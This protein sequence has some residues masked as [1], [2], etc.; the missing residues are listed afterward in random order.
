MDGFSDARVGAATAQVS[1]K[2]EVDIGIG[3]VGLLAEQGGGGHD[4]PALAVAALGDLFGNPSLLHHMVGIGRKPFDGGD[5]GGGFDARNRC[6]AGANRLV[7]E[8]NGAGTAERHAAAV[9]CA[10]QPDVVAHDP[11]ER[12]IGVGFE[13]VFLTVD[14]EGVFCHNGRT[15]GVAD[16]CSN[17]DF[18]FKSSCLRKLQ[19]EF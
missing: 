3:G 7:V 1:G 13:G 12:G 14:V 19:S 5:A 15:V 10:G 9:F 6:G 17:F 11:E 18:G 4:L 2:R 8:V 16:G